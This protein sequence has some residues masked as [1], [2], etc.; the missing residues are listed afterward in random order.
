MRGITGTV[1]SGLL[2]LALPT[3]CLAQHA[4]TSGG[5]AAAPAAHSISPGFGHSLPAPRV[6]T[7]PLGLTAPLSSG[8]S[9]I[10]PGALRS[11]GYHYRGRDFRRVPYAYFFAPYYYP[12]LDYGSAAYSDYDPGWDAAAA[13]PGAQGALMAQNM[14]GDQLNR[15][16]AEVEE[17]RYAQTQG[18]QPPPLQTREDPGPPQAPLTLVLRDGQKLKVQNYAVVEETFWDFTAEPARKI[19]IAD[20]DVA[21]SAKATAAGG[22]EFPQLAA[23]DRNGQ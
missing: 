5:H 12:F 16:S 19:P 11:Y 17:L 3:A 23:G 20:I 14:L 2:A 13:D 1:L 9:G 7:A 4:F 15:L 8:Y 22:G 21:A 6:G 18:P 10:R